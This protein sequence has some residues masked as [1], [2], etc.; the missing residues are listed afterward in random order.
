[1]AWQ[2]T[3][4]SQT[5]YADVVKTTFDA[6]GD[7]VTETRNL[8]PYTG[9]ITYISTAGGV[10]TKVFQEPI[11]DILALQ[12]IQVKSTENPMDSFEVSIPDLMPEEFRPQNPIT[13]EE[14]TAIGSASLP[15]LATG[16][17][18]AKETQVSYNVYRVTISGRASISLPQT[19][20]NKEITSEFGGGD[21]TEFYS[22]SLQQSESPT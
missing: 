18:L 19:I 10:W 17:L 6:D 14:S 22:R 21:V 1:M 13:T 4:T 9:I 2:I 15:T 3:L 20:T 16:I 12:V 5:P 8:Q 7:L 11:T